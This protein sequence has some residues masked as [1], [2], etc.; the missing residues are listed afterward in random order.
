M[1]KLIARDVP[2][3]VCARRLARPRLGIRERGVTS[4]TQASDED[5]E[6]NLVFERGRQDLGRLSIHGY[7]QIRY[8]GVPIRTASYQCKSP[9]RRREANGTG[10]RGW[11]RRPFPHRRHPVVP[12]SSVS[13]VWGILRGPNTEPQQ[14]NLMK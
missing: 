9:L 13:S 1:G 5:V 4:S 2:H 14:V 3:G 10:R 11:S 8:F 6:V 12:P 7:G